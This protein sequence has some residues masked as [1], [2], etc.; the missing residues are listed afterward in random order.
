[1][2][3]EQLRAKMPTALLAGVVLGLGGLSDWGWAAPTENHVL[4]STPAPSPV[5]LE[6][7]LSDWDRSGAIVLAD[8]VEKPRHLVRVTSMYDRT[9][10]Y[11]AFEFKDPTPMVNHV[12]P[13]ASPGE[14]NGRWAVDACPRSWATPARSARRRGSFQ[15]TSRRSRGRRAPISSSTASASSR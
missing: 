12:D 15:Y 11:L 14:S 1:M 2:L 4:R 9:S 3:G 8:D 13:V 5:S 10:L 7:D 6:R